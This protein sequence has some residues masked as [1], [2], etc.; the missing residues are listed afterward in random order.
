MG[1][2][3]VYIYIYP[4]WYSIL[5]SKQESQNIALAVIQKDKGF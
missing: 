2:P 5:D 1:S 4:N 3:M